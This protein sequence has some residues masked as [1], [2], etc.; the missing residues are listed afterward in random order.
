MLFCFRMIYIFIFEMCVCL[1]PARRIA[2]TRAPVA[3][4]MPRITGAVVPRLFGST[5]ASVS[6]VDVVTPE[7]VDTLE[8]TLGSPPTLHQFEEPPIVVEIAHLM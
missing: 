8:W 5:G 1:H 4:F 2:V 7:L 3:R 6:E